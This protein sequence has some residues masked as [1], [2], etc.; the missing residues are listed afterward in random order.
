METT[1]L[2]NK[3]AEG[4]SVFAKANDNFGFGAIEMGS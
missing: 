3:L 2:A 1:P 4:N